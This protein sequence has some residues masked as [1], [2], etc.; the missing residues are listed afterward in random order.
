MADAQNAAAAE[1]N[2]REGIYQA[3]KELEIKQVHF[4]P[5][6]GH[7]YVIDKCLAD[8]EMEAGMLANEFESVGVCCGAWLG[9]QRAAMLMQSSGIGNITHAMGLATSGR[10]PFF[11][12][13]TM[14]GEFGEAN[15]W[16]I[17]MG[18]NTEPVL[19]LSGFTCHRVEKPE[20]VAPVVEASINFAYL[21]STPVAV[22]LGQRLIGAKKFHI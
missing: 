8:P 13:V 16:Q 9:G 12:I 7:S 18:Q 2:W 5:D 6:A 4:V 11:T 19:E 15:P 22:I 10:F 1:P 21:A 3:L 17:P 14:R 20:D